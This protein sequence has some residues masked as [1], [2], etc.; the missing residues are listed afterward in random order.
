[1]AH[2]PEILGLA[3]F[4]LVGQILEELERQQPGSKERILER[5]KSDM[6]PYAVL[7]DGGV[8]PQA[9]LAVLA[10]LGGSERQP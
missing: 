1:M 5:A 10:G 8:V 4:V 9:I 3:G 7:K 6:A 2:S